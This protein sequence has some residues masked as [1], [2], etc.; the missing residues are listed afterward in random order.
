[1]DEETLPPIKPITSIVH[2]GEAYPMPAMVKVRFFD[3]MGRKHGVVVP[4]S[5]WGPEVIEQLLNESMYMSAT[6]PVAT[7]IYGLF[8]VNPTEQVWYELEEIQ[9]S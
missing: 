9:N 6:R 5:T 3:R 1:M 7:V 2:R 8:P 4:L